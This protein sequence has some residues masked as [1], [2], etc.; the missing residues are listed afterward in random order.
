MDST[1]APERKSTSSVVNKTGL[2]VEGIGGLLFNECELPIDT[3]GGVEEGEPENAS[4]APDDSSV[5]PGV[6]CSST[7][8]VC[9]GGA[10]LCVSSNTFSGV[11]CS[12]SEESVMVAIVVTSAKLSDSEVDI[13]VP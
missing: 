9:K 12:R 5:T 7:E 11:I 3:V 6:V 4:V 8:G 13:L 10:S 2:T 1:G